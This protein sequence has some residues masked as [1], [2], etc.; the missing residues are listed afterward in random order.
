[1][2]IAIWVFVG[3]AL[4][5]YPFMLPF[6]QNIISSGN[7]PDVGLAGFSTMLVCF[8]F[9][10]ALL[11]IATRSGAR[12]WSWI[13]A[14]VLMILYVVS[15]AGVPELIKDRQT[16]HWMI[17]VPAL[18]Q[19]FMLAYVVWAMVPMAGADSG[20]KGRPPQGPA[21]CSDCRLNADTSSV[22]VCARVAA[23]ETRF[24][25]AGRRA[26]LVRAQQLR[27]AQRDWGIRSAAAFLS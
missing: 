20:A 25:G 27:V 18:G 19:V 1:M 4:L 5:V 6:N 3:F 13:L 12:W 22:R 21:G 15:A 16:V 24:S 14:P 11:L 2:T 10:I 17:V 8:N 26:A 9:S 23:G 7:T